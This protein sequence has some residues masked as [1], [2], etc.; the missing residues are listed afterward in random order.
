M[1]QFP[2]FALNPYVFRAQYLHGQSVVQRRAYARRHNTDRRRWVSPF[3]NPRIKA[4]SQ[5]PEAYRSVPRPSSPLS[6]K[7]STECP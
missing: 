5:L 4:R 6:A 3:G 2:G 1:F 7:A